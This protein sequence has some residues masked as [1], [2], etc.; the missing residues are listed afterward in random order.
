MSAADMVNVCPVCGA[1]EGLDVLLA[2]MFADP[3]VRGLI[4]DVLSASLPL[5]PDLVRYLRLH[6]PPKQR[7]RLA[8]VRKLL[9]ELVPDVQRAAIER[10]GRVWAVSPEGWRAALHAV[11]DNVE[12]G[13]VTL[14]LEGNGYL[15][16]VLT[17]MADR[18][19]AS[20]E[21]AHENSLRGR[22]YQAG[23]MAVGEA[24]E[25]PPPAHRHMAPEPEPETTDP[26]AAARA[27]A[28]RDQLR[29]ELAAKRARQQGDAEPKTNEERT[30]A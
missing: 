18:A 5:G 21:K 6:K 1:E 11:F 7:L 20:D 13:S 15:Y 4:A 27:Q 3:E 24:V 9:A 23:G 2:R 14:P 30:D 22:A 29:A 28:I 12:R 17:R 10:H 16:A 8:T 25:A 19:E 26:E